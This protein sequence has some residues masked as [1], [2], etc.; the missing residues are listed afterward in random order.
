MRELKFIVVGTGRCG[1]VYM[2]RLLT[3][4][5]IPCG[6]ESI[7]S[8]EGLQRALPILRGHRQPSLSYVSTCDVL[9]NKRL[10]KWINPKQIVAESSYMAAPFLAEAS[11]EKVPIIHIARH[12]QQVISSF[13]KD[14]KYFHKR[15]P[16][17]QEFI[18]S[19][20]PE[21][22]TLETPL[23]RACC[24]YVKWNEMIERA[25]TARR[26]LFHLVEEMP[27]DE[28]FE[29]IDVKPTKDIFTDHCA[30]TKR[31]RQC[32]F[33]IK[34]I[35]DGP[36]KDAFRAMLERYGYRELRQPKLL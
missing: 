24:F 11:I 6:H 9:T 29:F 34:Q 22:D 30:N 28:F 4:L 2:A 32:E 35:P 8:F 16:G 25:Y 19:H 7:F 10:P 13:V 12:P 15:A 27:S 33:E 5:G 20:V 17:W 21:L 18:Y 1:T 3:G 14:F 23:E 26:H 31:R 36:T